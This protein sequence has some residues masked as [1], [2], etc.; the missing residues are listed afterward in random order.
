MQTGS[1]AFA[2]VEE[3]DAAAV[4]AAALA[5]PATPPLARARVMFRFR[6]LLEARAAQIAALISSEHGKVISDARGELTRGI[7]VVE[8]ACGI[9]QLLKGEF[10]GNVGSAVDST[11]LRQPLGVVAGI[12][13]FNFPAMVP[14]WMFPVAIASGNTFMLKPSERDPGTAGL[15]AELLPKPCRPACSATSSRRP[16]RRRCA[17]RSPGRG[18][19]RLR[20]L[21]R[22]RWHVY[23]RGCADR[24]R[25]GARRYQG[26]LVVTD[27]D[28][29]GGGR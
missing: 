9:P 4:Q 21:D 8:F 16:D 13:P 25:A 5:F 26:Y 12:T 24:Q 29:V 19:S 28:L 1:V 3:V 23:A 2:S 10:S 20:R 14:M 22:D 15:L 6:E 27:A 17:A 11:A 7:E 18:R